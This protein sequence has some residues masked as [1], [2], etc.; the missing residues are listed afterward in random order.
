MFPRSGLL[1]LSFNEL[2]QHKGIYSVLDEITRNLI[3][4]VYILS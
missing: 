1:F 3:Y 2:Q 4:T